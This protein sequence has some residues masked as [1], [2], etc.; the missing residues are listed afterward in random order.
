MSRLAQRLYMNSLRIKLIAK[1]STA[2]IAE[3]AC[4]IIT[5]ASEVLADFTAKDNA[6][7]LVEDISTGF[8]S[9][10]HRFVEKLEEV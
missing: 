10:C 6:N 4:V 8:V 1:K 3:E 9:A 5:E 2:I 7:P